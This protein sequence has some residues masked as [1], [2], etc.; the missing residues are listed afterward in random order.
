MMNPR[1]ERVI[2]MDGEY[3]ERLEVEA[4]A[5]EAVLTVC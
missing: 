3:L 1:K 2:E 4:M 5:M